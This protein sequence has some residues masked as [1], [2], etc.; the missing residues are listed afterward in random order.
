MYQAPGLDY[1]IQNRRDH[2]YN[3]HG[4]ISQH[5]PQQNRAADGT[6]TAVQYSGYEPTPSPIQYVQK[7]SFNLL[8]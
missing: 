2:S 6:T 4:I 7:A 5:I 1:S 8:L 3:P